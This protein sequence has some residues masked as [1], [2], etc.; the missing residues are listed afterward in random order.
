MNSQ[1]L[2]DK[3]GEFSSKRLGF[4]STLLIAIISTLITLATLLYKD[5]LELAISL[6]DSI[7]L[8]SFGFAGVV[9]T[10]FFG[11]KKNEN[12]IN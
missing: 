6:I 5:K 1:F 8:A 12:D 9:A 4:L 3:N 7:W 11:K 2:K 10:E